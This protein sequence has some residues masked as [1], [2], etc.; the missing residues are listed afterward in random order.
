MP[1]TNEV[2]MPQD[3]LQIALE[4][5]RAGRLTRAESDYRAIL[6]ADP[7]HADALHWLGVLLF[8]A[9]QV[10]ESIDLLER[11]ARERTEDAAFVH[12]LAQAYLAARRDD[13]AV[14][15]FEHAR[16]HGGDTA[17]LHYGLGVAL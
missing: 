3:S 7:E 13:D 6:A 16:E 14:A 10:A 9:G 17:D 15:A 12:N 2:P 8:Q 5:H 11:A 4:H 1:P